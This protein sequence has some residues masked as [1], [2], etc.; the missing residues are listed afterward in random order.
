MSD[1]GNLLLRVLPPKFLEGCMQIE[2]FAIRDLLLIK[3]VKHSDARGFFSEVYRSDVLLAVGVN[4]EF[5]Q[6]NH[7]F[8]EKR[9]VLRGLHFQTPPHAQGKL[10]RC[11]RGA[12]LDVAVDI[13]LGSP[14][15]GHHVAVELS[16]TN[17]QQLWVPS[18]FAHGYLTLESACEVM[19]KVTQYWHPNSERGIAWDDPSLAINWG[20][21]TQDLTIADKDKNNP[22]LAQIEPVFRYETENP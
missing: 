9:G 4:A 14:T 6:D 18:G 21:A 1:S 20:I 22:R 13:R 12:I 11:T 8:S 15:F 16:A 2:R 17:W 10:V 5:V 19:Y 3:P 7:V